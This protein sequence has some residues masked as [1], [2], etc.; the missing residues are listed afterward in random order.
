VIREAVRSIWQEPRSPGAP[1]RVGR[2]WVLVG[3]L[4]AT[5]V[6][7]GVLREDVAW[8]PLVT[9]LAVAVAVALL[10][11]RTHPLGVVV[12]GWGSALGL[13]VAPWILGVDGDVGLYTMALILLLPYALLRWGSGR[14]VVAGLAV[15][16]TVAALG[17][18]RDYT[19]VGDAV[20]A[21]VAVLLPAVVGVEVR[22]HTHARR[23]EL[24]QLR[25]EERGQLARELH[26]TVA[27]HVSAIAVRAQAGR[28]LAASDSAAAVDALGVIESEASRTLAEMRAMVGVLRD[29]RAAEL[30]PQRRVL[31]IAGLGREEPAPRIDVE[32]PA[33]LRDLTPAIESALFR[34]AQESVTNAV[35]H[36]RGATLVEVRLTEEDD[37]VRIRVRDNGGP[38]TAGRGTGYGLIGMSERAALLGGVLEAGP[39]PSG[40]WVVDA[41]LPR[42]GAHR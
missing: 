14:E 24:E 10:W 42:N 39:Q 5:A 1:D 28:V 41:V 38:A 40:G 22:R 4:V 13:T 30:T 21:A 26:D 15:V 2:D 33:D 8:R 6:L 16:L 19:G 32:V 35:R 11:R 17:I 34:I 36:A 20:A 12:L 23:R 27:H 31:D 7:E 9:L 37:R 18:A 3:G 25:L 29:G